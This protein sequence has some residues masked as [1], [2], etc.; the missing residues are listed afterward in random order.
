MTTKNTIKTALLLATLTALF[1][2][3]GQALGGT[4]GML[5]ALGFATLMNGGAY[6]FSGRLA[7]AMSHARP[8]SREE[9]PQLHWLVEDLAHRA[10]VP[11]PTLYI[12][13]DASPNAFA[14]GRDPAH[15]AV[16]VTRGMVDLL[17]Q[18][19]LYGVLAH[20]FAH[21]KH[22]DI[23]L[24]S[25]AAT[26]AGAITALAHVFQFAAL[27][28]HHD[29]DRE[30]SGIMGSIALLF[31]APIAATL[32]QLAISRDREFAADAAGAQLVNDPLSLARALHKLEQGAWVRPMAVNPATAS[33]YIVHP[34]AG[35]GILQ[36]FQTH[37]PID[38]RVARLEAMAREAA[39]GATI[40]M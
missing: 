15:A 38:D 19:E 34:R 24:S 11:V 8:V 13:D 1:A 35:G 30:D 40:A 39:P 18:R 25:V 22:R 2:W 29:E 9:E 23:L 31:L 36:L 16:A 33:M 14:T 7:I 37:P 5:L 28:G 21:I 4:T 10:G 6:W 3:F 32:I 20:E 26:V 12:I 27:F 17:N